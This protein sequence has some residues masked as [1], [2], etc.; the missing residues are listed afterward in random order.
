MERQSYESHF[1]ASP[2]LQKHKGSTAKEPVF[3]PNS[4]H[5]T[6]KLVQTHWRLRDKG[7]HQQDEAQILLDKQKTCTA[8]HASMH[9]KRPPNS[10]PLK[11][12]M[13]PLKKGE[14]CGLIKLV[15]SNE[16][17]GCK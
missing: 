5:E 10:Q 1:Q 3:H 2:F 4:L 14:R 7:G 17:G 9:K 6:S 8:H 16:H 12:P 11:K 15:E 13:V